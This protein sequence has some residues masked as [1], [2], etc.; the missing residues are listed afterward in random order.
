MPY[1]GRCLLHP[2]SVQLLLED[3]ELGWAYHTYRKLAQLTKAASRNST[4][5]RKLRQMVTLPIRGFLLTD[6][7]LLIPVFTFHSRFTDSLNVP[8]KTDK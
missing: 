5:K 8:L 4:E 3:T 2:G 6:F 7:G 1:R